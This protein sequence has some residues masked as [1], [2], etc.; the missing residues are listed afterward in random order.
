[1]D[2]EAWFETTPENVA[3]YIAWRTRRKKFIIDGCSGV[4]GNA[5]QFALNGADVLA[6]DTSSKRIQMS[7]HNAYLYDIGCSI[8]FV[9]R[10]VSELVLESSYYDSRVSCFH[11]SPPWGGRKCYQRPL[12]GLDDLS[13]RLS[14]LLRDALMSSGSVVVQLPRNIDLDDIRQ[15]LAVLGVWYFEIERICFMCPQP[16]IKFYY[17]YVDMSFD[18]RFTLYS[19]VLDV[20]SSRLSPYLGA[21]L[22]ARIYR[23]IFIKV[24]V[25]GPSIVRL[26]IEHLSWMGVK[27]SAVSGTSI[28]EL[29]ERNIE[30]ASYQQGLF[31]IPDMEY[32]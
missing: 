28:A 11:I 12:I 6:V 7:T 24:S 18:V 21:G 13:M 25:L 19:S 9:Q 15:C 4:G 30:I 23:D 22:T 27:F 26:L 5:I 2:R 32:A 16:R 17:L 1:M 3:Q 20:L 10:D 14:G 29:R 31:G 8:K